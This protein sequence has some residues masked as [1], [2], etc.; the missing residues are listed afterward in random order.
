MNGFLGRGLKSPLELDRSGRIA[1]VEDEESVRQSIWTILGTAPGE[2]VMRPEFGCGLHDLVFS[3]NTAATAGL[4]DDGVRR[5]LALWDPRIDVLA[6]SVVSS[7]PA[8]PGML[9]IR[10]EYRV[11][12]TNNVFN[13][14]YPFYLEGGAA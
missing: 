13:L 11:R 1:K 10:I 7:G 5:A 6:V 2:R 9:L 12:A 14:V 8:E 4:A 3:A